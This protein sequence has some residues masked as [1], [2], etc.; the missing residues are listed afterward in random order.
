MN[1]VVSKFAIV[2]AALVISTP[3]AFARDSLDVSGKWKA[4]AADAFS[5]KICDI[6]LRDSKMFGAFSA[7][8]FACPG[9]LFG[10]N[11]WRVRGRGVV[12]MD[13]SENTLAT[14][15]MRGD[16]LVGRDKSGKPVRMWRAGSRGGTSIPQAKRHKG[17][18][19]DARSGWDRRDNDRDDCIYNPR[20]RACASRH[21]LKTPR[22]G[23]HINITTLS[24]LRARPHANARI[25][26]TLKAN[27]CRVVDECRREDGV[28]WCRI[29]KFGRDGYIRQTART[30]T[31]NS[32]R[33]SGHN[34]GRTLLLFT[35]GCD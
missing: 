31:R 8:S 1:R 34:S 10:V 19:R 6:D 23:S 21:D 16:E 7:S 25:V 3:A 30:S 32:S 18:D 12:L 2:V 27:S 26:G 20:D 4:E 15:H 5:R 9:D 33:N 24:N 13:M 29:G 14:L 35:R 22:A 28:L 11:K 17:W